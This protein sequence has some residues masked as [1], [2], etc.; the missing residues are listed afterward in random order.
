MVGNNNQM[1]NFVDLLKLYE[2]IYAHPHDN[3]QYSTVFL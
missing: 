1:I 3:R 2:T